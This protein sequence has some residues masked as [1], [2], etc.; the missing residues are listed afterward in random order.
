MSTKDQ[1]NASLASVAEVVDPAQSSVGAAWQIDVTLVGFAGLPAPLRFAQITPPVIVGRLTIEQL[2]NQYLEES[3]RTDRLT[4]E[5]RR[6]YGNGLKAAARLRIDGMSITEYDVQDVGPGFPQRAHDAI[7]EASGG[8]TADKFAKLMGAAH[9][10]AANRGVNLP[11]NPWRSI[12]RYGSPAP[13]IDFPAGW[14][15]DALEVIERAKEEGKLLHPRTG[16]ESRLPSHVADYYTFCLCTGARPWCEVL[17]L[18]W[19]DLDEAR[20]TITF[21]FSKRK[22]GE[23]RRIRKLPLEVLCTRGR[24]VLE[25]QRSASEWVWASPADPSKHSGDTRFA[26]WWVPFRTWAAELIPI[27]DVEGEPLCLYEAGRHA[28]AS[29]LHEL[30]FSRSL[31]SEFLGHRDDKVTARYVHQST[32]PLVAPARL[33]AASLQERGSNSMGESARKPGLVLERLRRA[34]DWLER[35]ARATAALEGVESSGL[36]IRKDDGEGIYSDAAIKSWKIGKR[37]PSLAVLHQIALQI[38]GG[39][40]LDWFVGVGPDDALPELRVVE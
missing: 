18:R 5:S 23:K 40:S 26:E 12:E 34:I 21:A 32:R 33:V 8:A 11:P 20:G 37:E 14:L 30:G 2:A 31:I 6:T 39:V 36:Q 38:G 3:K 35:R 16:R 27:V 19:C 9:R 25:R 1:R 7:R 29:H 17:K 4:D 15:L 10:Y 13:E 22:K 28:F 24:E